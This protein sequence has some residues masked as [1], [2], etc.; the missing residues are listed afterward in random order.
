MGLIAQHSANASS[1]DVPSSLFLGPPSGIFEAS[2]RIAEPRRPSSSYGRGMGGLALF[3]RRSE[4]SHRMIYGSANRIEAS[5]GNADFF[6]ERTSYQ[7]S[8]GYPRPRVTKINT[9]LAVS[10]HGHMKMALTWYLAN[11]IQ[12]K[13]S[14]MAVA[15]NSGERS[16][17]QALWR[18]KLAVTCSDVDDTWNDY[19]SFLPTQ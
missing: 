17:C 9:S 5:V 12:F 6:A 8:I 2:M 18:R 14:G 1:C 7:F 10:G 15:G 13:P 19:P 3:I 4:W 11:R 16:P